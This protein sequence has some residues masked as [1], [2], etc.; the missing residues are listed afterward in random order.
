MAVAEHCRL[1]KGQLYKVRLGPSGIHFFNRHS[2]LNVLVDEIVPPPSSWAEAPRQVSI[3][4]TNACDLTCSYCF[5]PKSPARLGLMQVLSWL[6]ELDSN[7]AIGVG[8]G[9]GEPTLHPE[10]AE[11]CAEAAQQTNLAVTFT[12]HGHRLT[13]S[14]LANLKGNVH[15]I[16]V[17]M[18]GVETTYERLRG[19]SFGSLTGRLT[20]IADVAP[21][22]I[23]CVVNSDTISEVET[24]ALVGE[25]SGAAELL[26]LPERP[27]STRGGISSIDLRKLGDWVRGYRGPLRLAISEDHAANLPI[28]NPFQNES[29]LRGYAHIDATGVIKRTSF[30]KT[31]IVIGSTGVMAALKRLNRC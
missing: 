12:T 28:C 30:D 13:D 19:R 31:G 5:A 27:V 3:A 25:T 8:F 20:A 29:G 26:L 18:D 4:L 23:N 22:G 1:R 21:F 17:S 9:G 24:V 2:G 15:F 16:R 11:L 6:R 7:G 10:F 14:L